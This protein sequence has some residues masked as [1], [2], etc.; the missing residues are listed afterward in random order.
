MLVINVC[1]PTLVMGLGFG[2]VFGPTT[3]LLAGGAEFGAANVDTVDGQHG[4]LRRG[5]GK[6]SWVAVG[7][8]DKTPVGLGQRRSSDR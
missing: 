3:E 2:F 6:L 4:A 1:V 7:L 5:I 8:H